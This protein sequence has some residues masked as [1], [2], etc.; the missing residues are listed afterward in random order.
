LQEDH[1]RLPAEAAKNKWS[2]TI[3]ILE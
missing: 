1:R 3:A 2:V